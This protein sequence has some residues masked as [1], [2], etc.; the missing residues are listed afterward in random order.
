[1]AEAKPLHQ[2]SSFEEGTKGKGH[3]LTFL[4]EETER[5]R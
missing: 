4:V 3:F 1:M 2:V 5:R